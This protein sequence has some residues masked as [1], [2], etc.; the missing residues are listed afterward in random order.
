MARAILGDVNIGRQ[1]NVLVTI[2]ESAAWRSLWGHCNLP[3]LTFQELGLDRKDS[4]A[5]IWQLCQQEQIILLTANRNADGP[6]SLEET[7]R[8]RNTPQSLPVFTIA[9]AQE[10]LESKA[11]AERVVES[12]L[13]YLL[14][15]DNVRGTG[16]LYL[17]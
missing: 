5:K 17:P 16:R 3:L 9:D 2:L 8:T 1:V 13:D 6:D 10:V 12:F 7:I 11:Y 4:D 15:L 14:D